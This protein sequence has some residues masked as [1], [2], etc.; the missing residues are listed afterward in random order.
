MASTKEKLGA[1]K[2][3]EK[4][5]VDLREEMENE[6]P[7]DV[8]GPDV[9]AV[10]KLARAYQGLQDGPDYVTTSW[11]NQEK[12]QTFFNKYGLGMALD[13]AFRL[14]AL[15]DAD[16]WAGLKWS[17]A[18]PGQQVYLRG[19]HAGFF[20]AYGGHVVVS[21]KKRTLRNTRGEV[22]THISEDLLTRKGS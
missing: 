15:V 5:Q 14:E 4:P 18:H 21:A 12:A 7:G 6:R 20:R 8:P 22:F 11:E 19:T 17:D 3:G 9:R 1:L 2:R 10:L 16:K 13:E